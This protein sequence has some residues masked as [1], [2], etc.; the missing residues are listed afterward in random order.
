[1]KKL[2]TMEYGK[3]STISHVESSKVDLTE[4]SKLVTGREKNAMLPKYII[5]GRSN[6]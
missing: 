3:F 6:F 1:M 4:A 5:L 2:K